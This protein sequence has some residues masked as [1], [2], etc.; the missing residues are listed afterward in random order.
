MQ[1]IIKGILF[2]KDGTLLDYQLSWRPINARVALHAARGSET[3]AS[4]LLAA[5]GY[6]AAT[7][8]VTSGSLLAAGTSREIAAGFI[9]AGSPYRLDELTAAVDEIFRAG[10]TGVVPVLDLGQFFRRLKR[11]GLALGI[12]SSDSEQAIRMTADRFGF[13]D[14]VDF[15]AGWDS[16]YLAKPAAGMFDAFARHSRIAPRHLAVVGDNLHDMEMAAAGG[17]GLKVGVLTGTSHRDHL[18]RACD[19]CLDSIR[20]LE[21]ALFG[22]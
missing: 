13:A 18:E 19:I 17:A 3:L 2:D 10:V 16:G 4:R 12:A 14:A 7:G 8:R 6:D 22:A 5:T 11:R 20:D 15:I 21:A 1:P 9:A